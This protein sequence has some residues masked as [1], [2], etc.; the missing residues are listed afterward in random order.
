M[1]RTLIATMIGLLMGV[2]IMVDCQ[3]QAQETEVMEAI[4]LPEPS[5]DGDMSVEE[6]INRRRS[7]RE[8]ADKALT[9][10]QLGQLT[11]SAQGTTEP[12]RGLRAAPSAGATYPLE[13]YLVTP[14]GLFQYRPRD[15]A[16]LQLGTADLRPELAAAAL[17]QAH[18]RQAP[19]DIVITG[20]YERTAGKYGDRA[21][22]YVHMEAGHAAENIH[23]QAVALGLGSVPVGAFDD[24]D[25]AGV[26]DLPADEAPLYIIPVG[27]PK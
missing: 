5:T 14:E 11:W 4:E 10:E 21:R 24:D 1:K 22:R 20:I 3:S 19:L 2:M 18:V 8:F 25:V 9:S 15:H 13:M 23:L 17:G 12:G 26:L 6:A 27:H 16:L 7:I